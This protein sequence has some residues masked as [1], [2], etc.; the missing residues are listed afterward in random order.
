MNAVPG[1]GSDL[2]VPVPYPAFQ[3]IRT[4]SGNALLS[5]LSKLS[6]RTAISDIIAEP[7][8]TVAACHLAY[9]C[10]CVKE[11]TSKLL[12][13]VETVIFLVPVSLLTALYA[14]SL[15]AM[16]ASGGLRTE[17]LEAHAVPIFTFVGL[18]LQLCGWRVVAAFLIDGRQGIR[19]VA[20]IYVYASV[21]GAAIVAA[22]GLAFLLLL[23][24]FERPLFGLLSV[25]YLALPALVPF[26]HAMIERWHS[27]RQRD[28]AA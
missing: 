25:N 26:I 21:L 22:S 24:G 8:M 23:A 1:R 5:V 20:T 18:I 15:T 13:L 14:L 19:A 7:V 6:C 28:A 10:S 2:N 11:R 12:L 27:R 4:K 9:R 16:Y 17:P 3:Q